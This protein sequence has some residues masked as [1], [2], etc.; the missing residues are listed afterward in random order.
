MY[1]SAK[2]YEVSYCEKLAPTQGHSLEHSLILSKSR[3]YEAFS[4]DFHF[5]S[6]CKACLV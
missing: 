2:D 3:P 4:L 1:D 5:L 6:M